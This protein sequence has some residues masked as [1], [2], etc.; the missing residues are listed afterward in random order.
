MKFW[1]QNKKKI[2]LRVFFPI[3]NPSKYMII[4]P[5]GFNQADLKAIF[6]NTDVLVVPSIWYETFG[7]TVIEALSYG[8][9]VIVSNHVGAKDLV[10]EN[11]IIFEAGNVCA[12]KT[13]L[14][15]MDEKKLYCLNKKQ[16]NE[17][18]IKTWN[19]F[20]SENDNIYK[21]L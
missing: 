20:V 3:D 10:G 1:K 4:E 21:S 12:L 8:V 17:S 18:K 14:L 6:D 2:E 5:K 15:S 9:P 13:I 11:G 16:K 19:E 7:F